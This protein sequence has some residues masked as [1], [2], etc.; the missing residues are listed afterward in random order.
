MEAKTMKKF[1]GFLAVLPLTLVLACGLLSAG[2]PLVVVE[3]EIL[4]DQ[5]WQETGVALEAG[6][7]VLIEY[8]SGQATD[9][10]L[11]LIDGSGSD[12]VCSAATC[13]EPLPGARRSSLIARVG[14][15]DEAVFY[16]GNGARMTAESG[17]PLFLRF[18]DCNSGLED[19][20]GAFRVRITR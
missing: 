14:G 1:P 10:D 18:N 3:V 17:G 5:G 9:G 4:A 11:L 6:E 8:L 13:C 2:E 16:V 19:N 15:T 7:S 12:Y 20:S